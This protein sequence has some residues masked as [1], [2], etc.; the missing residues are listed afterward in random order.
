[1]QKE[2]LGDSVYVDCDGWSMGEHAMNIEQLARAVI[3]AVRDEA[4]HNQRLAVNEVTNHEI[5]VD[6]SNCIPAGQCVRG[7]LVLGEVG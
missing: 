4:T 7:L 5:R 1:M 3:A 2:Y 6:N